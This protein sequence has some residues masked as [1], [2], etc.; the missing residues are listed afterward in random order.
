MQTYGTHGM[1]CKWLWFLLLLCSLPNFE[2]R[3]LLPTDW[4]ERVANAQMLAT[5]RDPTDQVINKLF[6]P[7]TNQQR[8]M[9]SIGNVYIA[10]VMDSDAIYCGGVYVG[11]GITENIC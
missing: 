1:H 3:A 2:G 8:F 10:T 7:I 5:P 6:R 9:P 11:N 4:I